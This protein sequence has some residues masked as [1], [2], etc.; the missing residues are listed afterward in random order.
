MSVN[1]RIDRKIASHIP[2]ITLLLGAFLFGFVQSALAETVKS[3]PG[4][5]LVLINAKI[6]T[7]WGWAEA[8][9]IENGIIAA[10]GSTQ[11]I[12]SVGASLRGTVD[13]AGMTVLPG[14]HDM[15]VHPLFA[16][17]ERSLPRAAMGMGVVFLVPFFMSYGWIHYRWEFSSGWFVGAAFYLFF[18]APRLWGLHQGSLRHPSRAGADARA[19][20]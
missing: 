18:A 3:E 9:A 12:M 4:R 15:H 17:L 20:E 14:L 7:P 16:G 2:A 11:E 13:L 19:S 1:P 6:K 8:M 10:V 5:D